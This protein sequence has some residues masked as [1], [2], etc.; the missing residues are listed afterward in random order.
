MARSVARTCWLAA[1][2]IC[3]RL[4]ILT[5]KLEING[6]SNDRMPMLNNTQYVVMAMILG[7]S[8]TQL[9]GI[10]ARLGIADHL[11]KGPKSSEELA[12]L[13]GIPEPAL[14]RFLRAIVTCGL[15]RRLLDDRF[16][17]TQ[18]G[19]ALR[20]GVAG[21]LRELAIRVHEIDYR[22][23]SGLLDSLREG[24]IPF[25]KVYGVGFYDYLD[26]WSLQDRFNDEMVMFPETYNWAVEGVF[27]FEDTQNVI[28]VGGGKGALMGAI[29]AS[30]PRT[31]GVVFDLPV[32]AAS[33]QKY[34]ESRSMMHRCRVVGGNFLVDVPTGGDVYILMRILHNWDDNHCLQILTN[35]RRAM[36]TGKKLVVIEQ[37]MPDRIA[38]AGFNPVV[39]SDLTMLVLVG[40]KERTETEF[41]ALLTKSGFEKRRLTTRDGFSLI[42]ATAR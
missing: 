29:L 4:L 31:I 15:I 1:R 28:D 37:I 34:L 10:A 18:S 19:E 5:G 30:H 20:A 39:G 8:R 12:K 35:C 14:F 27:G 21:S 36:T 11:A 25:N 41:E 26:Q 6:V 24:D 23:W 40:G 22:A 32:V 7:Y 16:S 38:D 13:T 33:A 2:R 3:N 42:E 17:L 9:V